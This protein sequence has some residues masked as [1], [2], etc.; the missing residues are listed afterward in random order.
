MRNRKG[1]EAIR[2]HITLLDEVKAEKDLL[3]TIKKAALFSVRLFC[4]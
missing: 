4:F 1:C 2:T 3:D